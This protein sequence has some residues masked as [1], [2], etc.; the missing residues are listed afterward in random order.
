VNG[1]EGAV[2]SVDGRVAADDG[3]GCSVHEGLSHLV[4]LLPRV[5]RG[6]RRRRGQ[7]LAPDISF[8]GPRH[9]SALAL[10]R[11][12]DSTVG[13]L[14]SELELN[15]ATVSGLV[16]DLERAGF[17]KRSTDLDDRRRTI[18]RI[19]PGSESVIDAWLEGATAPIV[20]ALEQLSPDERATFIK[21]MGLLDAQ[22]SR[23]PGTLEAGEPV[24]SLQ[25]PDHQ[26]RSLVE[27]GVV[28]PGLT[29][30]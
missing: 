8:L 3:G 9:G 13:G 29:S 1:D 14:A 18:V 26:T 10:V 17:V 19:D 16:A 30:G 15:V 2:P 22:L 7:S 4:Q 20:R 28:H 23:A 27:L 21:A 24:Q 6:M 25:K 12:G 11:Q 5:M